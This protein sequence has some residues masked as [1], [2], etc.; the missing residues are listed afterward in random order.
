MYTDSRSLFINLTNHPYEDWCARQREAAREY[1]E[2]VDMPFPAID[3]WGDKAYIEAL[4]DEYLHRV[5]T[6][7]EVYS[8]TVHLMGELTFSFALLERLRQ[9]GIP[10]IASTSKRLVSDESGGHKVVTFQFA[11]FRR[12]C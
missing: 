12:Y 2:V 11:R 6:Y 1:G 4:A 3:E 10:V 7:A 9:Q 5:L 8:V